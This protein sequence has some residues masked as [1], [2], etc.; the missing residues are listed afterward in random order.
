MPGFVA[1][2]ALA[3]NGTEGP[4]QLSAAYVEPA[5]IAFDIGLLLGRCERR[6]C[7]GDDH[8]VAGHG[9][10]RSRADLSRQLEVL[11]ERLEQVDD[12]VRAKTGYRPTR[13]RVERDE[14]V[15]R[16]EVESPLFAAGAPIGEP[17]AGLCANRRRAALSFVEAVNPKL[18]ASRRIERRHGST[19]SAGRI[20]LAADHQWSALKTVL[21]LRAHVGDAEAP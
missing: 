5:N 12:A 10:R 14:A 3:W 8:D 9:R 17:A 15:A 18:L 20:E 19:C 2:F 6:V 16:R 21:G 4:K 11:V 1:L 7:R 13:L